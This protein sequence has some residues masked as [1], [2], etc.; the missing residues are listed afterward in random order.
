MTSEVMR[1]IRSFVRRGGRET[2]AQTRAF[3]EA[4]EQYGI[5]WT[6]QSLDW[7]QLFGRHAKRVLE[8]GYGNGE[9]LIHM[10]SKHPDWDF[11][12]I[13][14]YRAG[15]GRLLAEAKSRGLTNI[16]VIM[17]DAVEVLEQGVSDESF[18]LVLLLFSD[19]WPKKRHHKR[20][21]VQ[22]S[23]ADLLQH[24]LKQQGIWHLATDW[25]NYAWHMREVLD[26]HPS[27]ENLGCETGFCQKPEFRVLTKF[28]NRGA[29]LGHSVFDMQYWKK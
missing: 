29:R 4:W 23:F 21:L 19:P 27:F 25:E 2:E 3:D 12:G 28:E 24:K 11:L 10:A 13:E 18:D 26:A 22:T 17:H 1:K 9:T 8:I 16:K 6:G 5:D 20:R 14:V 15:T 7:Q